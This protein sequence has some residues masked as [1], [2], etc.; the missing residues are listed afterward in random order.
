M[1]VRV[2]SG[3]K[4]KAASATTITVAI[5]RRSHSPPA[6]LSKPA[7]RH[8]RQ[9]H[10]TT[11]TGSSVSQPANFFTERASNVRIPLT[12]DAAS[13][14]LNPRE[15]NPISSMWLRY[16]IRSESDVCFQIHL[17]F[18]QLPYPQMISPPF[19]Q[20]SPFLRRIMNMLTLRLGTALSI[21]PCLMMNQIR[22]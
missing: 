15:G 9:Q 13:P 6:G 2:G 4:P 20:P 8:I 17:S 7:G 19:L 11:L 18:H 21:H 3:W 10:I 22:S 1:V 14:S 5:A 12:A 16:C